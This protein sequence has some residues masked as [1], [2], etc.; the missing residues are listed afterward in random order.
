MN[1]TPRLIRLLAATLLLAASPTTRGEETGKVLR[2][3]V[4]TGQSNSLGTVGTTDTT[5]R[6]PAPGGHPAEQAG[7]VPF[8]WN[9]RADGT[10]AGD[11]GLGDSGGA[12]VALGAQTGGYY[13]GN[14]DHWGPEIG[15]SRMLWNCG[16][17]D[18]A[19]VKA[20]RGGGGNT[21][22]S[23]GSADDHMYQHVLSTVNQA[24]ASLPPGYSSYQIAGLL[25]VQGESNSSAEASAAGSRFS[26]LLANLKADLANAGAMTGVFGEI[27][28]SGT[29]RDTTRA[30]QLALSNSRTDVGYAESNGLATHN[31]DG[32]N[33][34]Y[35]AESQILLGER[36][37]AEAI[38]VG[39]FPAKPLPA[40]TGLRAWYVAD[41]GMTFDGANA[42]NRWASLHDGK[43]VRDLTRRVAGQTFRRD[44]TSGAGQPRKVMRFDGGNDL[45]ANA[46]TEFGAISGARTVAVLCR[47]TS[48]TRGYLFDGSTGT[49]RSRAQIRDGNWQAGAAASWDVADAVT[50]PLS[51]NT[52]Q[53]HVFTFEP[54]GTGTTVKHWI[55]GVLQNTVTDAES[56][57]LGGFI[58]GSNGGSPF[59]RVAADVA[60]IAVYGSA[61]G[62]TEVAEL[63]QSWTARWGSPAG[64]PFAVRVSQQTGVV[65]RFGWHPVLGIQIDNDAAT[66]ALESLRVA[67]SG[68]ARA[69][70]G[71]WAVF[72]TTGASFN[73]SGGPLAVVAEPAG[74]EISFSTPLGLL[75]GTRYLWIAVEPARRSPIG[76]TLDAALLDLNLSGALAGV[77]APPD[78]NPAGSLQVGLVPLFSDVVWSG[79]N[80][81]NTYRIPGVVCDAN[82]TLHAVYDLR[83][84]SSADLPANVDVGY[85]RSTDGGATWSAPVPILDFDSSIA[86]SSGNGVGDPCI[87]LDPT[88]D[89]LWVAA[90]WSFGNRAYSGSGPGLLPSETGQYVLTKSADGGLTWSASINVTSSVKA[91][92]NWNLIFQ[93]PGHGLAM[94]DGTLVFPSQYRDSTG[95]VRVCSVYSA[96]HGASW[97]FGSG[98]PTSS[99]QTNENTVCELDDG[100]LLFS[101]R[102][103]SG[104]NGQRAWIHYTPGGSSPLSDGSWSSL[105]RLAAVPD[106]VCQ[107]S[108]IQWTSTHR[109]NPREL[110]VFGNPASSSSRVNFTLRVSPDGGASWPVSRQVYSGSSA[111][112]S[113]CVLPDRSIGILLEKD[114]Y[115]KITFIRVEEEWLWNPDA[116]AD[117]DQLPD[118]WETIH[119]TNPALDDAAAD[120]DG[121]GRSHLEEYRSGTDPQDKSSVLRVD[122]WKPLA[123]GF[124]LDWS[125]IPGRSYMVERSQD[126]TNWSDHQRVEAVT[127]QSSVELSPAG[128][129]SFF[130]VRAD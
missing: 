70:G 76:G 103:P 107:G 114:N 7:G 33:L 124:K 11:A 50:A 94:R 49:G 31:Q 77:V 29:D 2:V 130:R 6:F 60:E 53:Q 41:N 129:K 69:A 44:V 75:D 82:G 68:S 89:T 123:A 106:P 86:G 84:N 101:M 25:Y 73:S 3:F 99:P 8:F 65:P 10:P 117:L 115:T 118:A 71:R 108:V 42:V 17:R 12:W 38:R 116:D 78:G 37:A 122:E 109:G 88:T 52:W 62:S 28:G 113:L 121:D 102:T 57:N 35:D 56:A 126:L 9:N 66:S 30:Q 81:V 63:S 47:I 98:V 43:A 45:W 48:G 19:I 72:S 18:F 127:D 1:R 83:Y 24:V 112:S 15:F 5:M 46:T 59:T 119:G 64:P 67:L 36:M 97:H 32:L 20:S 21:Y 34:H 104:S 23:K 58:V 100:R 26:D 105:Y 51:V 80:A 95:T 111:Y 61:L 92:P 22:W 54:N 91:D 13:A 27:A 128:D 39:A 87:L 93:G 110:I 90:L 74:N 16:Y 79:L 55:D 120:S 96:D 40:W 85:S 4:L 14:D 125:S